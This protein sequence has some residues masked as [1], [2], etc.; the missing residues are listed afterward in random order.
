[1]LAAASFCSASP[2]LRG[3][4]RRPIARPMQCPRSVSCGDAVFRRGGDER[5]ACR[6][7]P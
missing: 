5:A 7:S 1:P 3:A 2:V 4:V 6:R